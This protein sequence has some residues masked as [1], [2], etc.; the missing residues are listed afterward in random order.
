MYLLVPGGLQRSLGP[1]TFLRGPPY[2]TSFTPKVLSLALRS[3]FFPL[4]VRICA[5]LTLAP[6]IVPAMIVHQDDF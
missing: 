1:A 3:H 5:S 6:Y 2:I 4:S